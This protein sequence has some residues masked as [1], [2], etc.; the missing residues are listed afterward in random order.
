MCSCYEY[1][2]TIIKYPT[3]SSSTI[4]GNTPLRQKFQSIQCEKKN[5][6]K[7]NWCISQLL[8]KSQ[9]KIIYD[10]KLEMSTSI[11]KN[12][13]YKSALTISTYL[14]NFITFPY[15]SRILG[16]DGI[17]LIGFVDNTLSYFLLFAT[18]GISILGVREVAA[19][20]NNQKECNRVYSNILGMN[21]A[22]TIITLIVYF[23]CIALIPKF[24]QYQELFYI[25]SAKILFTAFMVEWFFSG[26][27]NFRYITI[28]S[29]LIKSLYV[30]FVF[31]FVR[32][33][34]DYM[35]YFILTV[36][37]VIVNAI[38]NMVYIR[39][40][41]SICVREL[42]SRKYLKQNITLGIYAI[43]TS[44]YLTFNVMFL[45]FV[46]N[47]TEVGYY[48][49]AFKLYSVI[50]GLFTAFTNVML[51]RMTSLL[52]EGEKD[53]FNS[54][55]NKSFESMCTFSIP[56]ILC[57]M[58]LAPQIIYIL[59]GS[60]YE[61][62]ILPMRIIM[63][64]V[65][66]VGIAQ[67]LALQV[68]LPMKKDK[69]LFI[70]SIFGASISLLVNSLVVPRMQSVGSAIV[71][72]TAESVV[73]LVYIIYTF[74]H[75][76]TI[77]SFKTIGKNLILSLPSVL[78]CYICGKFIENYFYSVAIAVSVSILLWGAMHILFRTWIGKICLERIHTR[79]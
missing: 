29:L 51:P 77:I 34:D 68:L 59:S 3:T 32:V 25:G 13:A 40:F 4:T 21:L 9:C 18:M 16:V 10:D 17:G 1:A 20:K 49:T 26:T 53:R 57:S 72:L 47:N 70:A 37:V 58:V 5:E 56:M 27:E 54:L 60:G 36:A 74:R 8:D 76:L 24:T 38:I 52:A 73:T 50:L 61:G 12:F 11:K 14:M 6:H 28:R 7:R 75:K 31:I 78:L 62:A 67:V 42:V 23:V 33:K 41:V 79:G 46:S 48:T 63:P 45:G 39:K 66:S 55:I 19:V 2:K 22:F 43:M 30:V 71:L 44:M 15:V 35:L 64:A 65:L 69:V